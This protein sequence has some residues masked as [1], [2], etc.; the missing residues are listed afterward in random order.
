VLGGE[1]PGAI[2]LAPKR[3]HVYESDAGLTEPSALLLRVLFQKLI[4]MGC[5]CSIAGCPGASVEHICEG[6]LDHRPQ[7][8]QPIRGQGGHSDLSRTCGFRVSSHEPPYL[9]LRIVGFQPPGECLG[10]I[11]LC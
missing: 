4:L 6:L 1:T 5:P 9:A 7:G 10:G 2:R 11:E 3:R 8:L